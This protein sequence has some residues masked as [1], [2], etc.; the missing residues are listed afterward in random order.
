MMNANEYVESLKKLRKKVY[1]FGEEIRDVT[2][3]PFLKPTLNSIALTYQLAHDER[4]RD[5]L[6]ATSH[7]TGRRIN[8]FTHIP[9]NTDDLVKKV[10]MLRLLGQKTGS[11]F[12][13]CVGMDAIITLSSVTYEVDQKYGTDYYK[14]FIRFLVR[15][16]DEDLMCGGSMTDVKGD[17][18]LRP[19]Q[20]KDPDMF[21]H[22]VERRDDGIVIRGAKAHQSGS[23]F[24]HELI[25]MPTLSM[26]ESDRDYAVSCAVPADADGVVYIVGRQTNDSRKM[27]ECEIDVGNLQ[28]SVAGHEA[29][30]VFDDVFVPWDRVFM[31]GEWDFSGV[32]VERFAS[33]HRQNYGGCKVGVGDVLIGAAATIADY[34]GVSD[35]SHIREKLV[36]MVYLNETMHACG[37]A[38]SYEG[39]KLPSGTYYVNPLLA[40][41]T[42]LNVTKFPFEMARLA[43]DITGGIIGTQPSE[44][45]FK[46]PAVGRYIEKYLKA[47][48]GIPTE[49]RMR[50]VR[51]IENMV[52]GT[53]LIESMHGA[54]SPQAQRIMIA[55]QADF[56]FKKKLAKILAG[57]EGG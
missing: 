17:R 48:E 26:R 43:V 12:Q 24:A 27:E 44:R 22:V 42:K 49:H 56:E 31:C 9:Q 40:N 23:V 1:M 36:E 39:V 52:T 13:R 35:A 16:Q 32:L 7:L 45:D 37:L 34:N 57:V 14:R 51:L 2:V 47:R 28:Y 41:V 33:Y 50:I 6:T 11:C 54:G 15:V 53:G 3:H 25:V 30:V 29:L 46:H 19:S 4:Y 8:R 20:Q 55:R 10:K 38:C 5:L 21:V 18:G